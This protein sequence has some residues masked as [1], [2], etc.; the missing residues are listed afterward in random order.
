MTPELSHAMVIAGAFSLGC[1]YVHIQYYVQDRYRL[2]L[3]FITFTLINLYIMW[4]L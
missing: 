1:V 3:W 2:L 4:T